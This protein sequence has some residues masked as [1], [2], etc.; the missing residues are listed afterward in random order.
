MPS[1]RPRPSLPPPWV[2][3]G[4]AA[5]WQL[6]Q[7]ARALGAGPDGGAE[8]L[9]RA[10]LLALALASGLAWRLAPRAWPAALAA[11]LGTALSLA[12]LLLEGVLERTELLARGALGLA[13]ATAVAG[14]WLVVRAG[15]RAGA[16]RTGPA[17]RIALALAVLL[18][19]LWTVEC[20]ARWTRGLHTY[21]PVSSDPRHGPCLFR[22]D[23]GA[24]RAN[25]G[26]RGRFVHREFEG[27]PV[28][29]NAL[30]LR[31][32][33][34]EVEPPAAGVPHVL[35]LGDSFA[36][37][38]GVSLE[39]TFQ[40]RLETLLDPR[41]GRPAPRVTGAGIPGFGTRDA[42]RQLAELGPVAAPDLVVLA[43]FEENDFQDNRSARARGPLPSP[44][45]PG[46]VRPAA[47]PAPLLGCLRSVAGPAFWSER[48]AA[49]QLGSSR[50]TGLPSMFLREALSGDPA[51]RV[52]PLVDELF[53]E[54]SLLRDDAEALGAG[55]VVLLVPS[56]LQAEQGRLE[57][58]R[59]AHGTDE[60][61]RPVA[62]DRRTFH[63][64]LASRLVTEGYTVVD[65]LELLAA[66]ASGYHREGHW[67]A[68]GH[69][70]AARALAPVLRDRLAID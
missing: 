53:D 30:G 4:A 33:D 9:L 67:N 6:V 32:G 60:Q 70:L 37:G 22:D 46:S 28:A 2:L 15:P 18:G 42:R 11:G 19:S 51:G 55:L 36:Y 57:R 12:L 45:T 61:G 52:A 44:E 65:P 21:D 10:A 41:D 31:D 26:Y 7:L 62:L 43:L 48:S 24:A 3:L 68:R 29:I 8:R 5:A 38:L 40:E 69:E 39:D 50:G 13:A 58:Y 35:C 1:A 34:D 14:C 56:A 23:H 66:G 17:P 47:G 54:L 63:D 49:L 27:V 25:P 20:L 59:A 16:G 64:A